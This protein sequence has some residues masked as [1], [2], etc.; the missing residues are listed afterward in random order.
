MGFEFP[1]KNRDA[2]LM[3]FVDLDLICVRMGN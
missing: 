1:L 2:A 3:H